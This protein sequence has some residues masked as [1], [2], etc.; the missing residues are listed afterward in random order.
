M[1]SLFQ[2]R[3][4]MPEFLKLTELSF[5]NGVAGEALSIPIWTD[6]QT[7]CRSFICRGATCGDLHLKA[8][9]GQ[10]VLP[11]PINQSV[12]TWGEARSRMPTSW[13]GAMARNIVLPVKA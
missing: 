6:K 12:A 2:E 7:F 13:E 1:S 11:T 3:D 4:I 8:N 5:N 10:P 9:A